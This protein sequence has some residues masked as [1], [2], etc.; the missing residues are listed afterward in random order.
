MGLV[1]LISAVVRSTNRSGDAADRASPAQIAGMLAVATV[2]ANVAFYF[3][4]DMYYEDRSAV[5]GMVTADHVAQ[6]RINFG[7]FTGSVAMGGVL[8]SLQPR[9]V[10]HLLAGLAAIAGVVGGVSAAAHEMTP[11][12]PASLIVGGGVMAVLVWKSL[13]KVRAA[14]AFLIGM[15][16]V[17][18]AVML[19]GATKLRS[20]L[21]VQLYIALIIPGLLAVATTALSMTRDDYKDAQ[22]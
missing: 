6:V 10:G 3:L 5:Y 17:L 22:A 13:M 7:I 12:L 8:A 14:W 16:S 15:T 2:I 9:Y 19:F 1:R 18:S 21:D 20:A 4:S 11:V